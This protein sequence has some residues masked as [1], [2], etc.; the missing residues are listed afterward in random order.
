MVINIPR[1]V[2]EELVEWAA[3]CYS[4][5]YLCREVLMAG[6]GRPRCYERKY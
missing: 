5:G 6:I 3:I 4:G 2:F 1:V